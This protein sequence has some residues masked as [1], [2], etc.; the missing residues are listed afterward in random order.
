MKEEKKAKEIF[1]FI[2]KNGLKQL[3]S[4]FDNEEYEKYNRL[5]EEV[6]SLQKEPEFVYIAGEI[7]AYL[8]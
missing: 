6:D 7:N 5:I 3:S 1:D 4:I 2:E 8:G